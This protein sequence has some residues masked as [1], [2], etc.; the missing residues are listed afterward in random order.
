M[1]VAGWGM[2]KGLG[3]L[4]YWLWVSKLIP[5]YLQLLVINCMEEMDFSHLSTQNREKLLTRNFAQGESSY[6]VFGNYANIWA[7][8]S[9]F[10]MT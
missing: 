1:Q 3:T 2:S 7:N 4:V 8:A 10:L 6:R 5:P 9:N